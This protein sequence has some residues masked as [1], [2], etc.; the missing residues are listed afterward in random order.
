MSSVIVPTLLRG[1]S[2]RLPNVRLTA[3]RVAD[4]IIS[5]AAMSAWPPPGGRS[6]AAAAAATASP[7]SAVGMKGGEQNDVDVG[8]TRGTPLGIPG[9]ASRRPPHEVSA[10][11]PGGTRSGDHAEDEPADYAVSMKSGAAASSVGWGCGWARIE[12]QLEVLSRG[13]PDR[14]VA[15]FANQALKPRWESDCS[16]R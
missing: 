2:D 7:S 5:V 1:L 9:E 13:D 6:A 10:G 8:S 3:A 14:D 15:F 4:D 16:S 12:M 11:M